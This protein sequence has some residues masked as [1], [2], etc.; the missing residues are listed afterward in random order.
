MNL[1]FLNAGRRCELL[2]SFRQALALRGGGQIHASDV[3]EHAPA[4]HHADYAHR[5]PH[6]SAA[7][8]VPAF[9]A[10]CRSAAIDLVIPTIDPDLDFLSRCRPEIERICPR[11][12][13]LLSP[14]PVIALCRDKRFTRARFAELGAA[15]PLAVDPDDDAVTFPIFM[16]P[17]TGSASEGIR[18]LRHRE[19]LAVHRCDCAEP[20][21]EQ[22]VTGPE[23]TV[24]VLC[25]FEGR[26]R[27]AV[28]RKRLQVRGGEVVKGVVERHHD[29][30]QLAMRLAE[31]FGCEGPVTLQF[32][33]PSAT[34]P[35][36]AM[37]INARMGGGLPLSIAAGADWPGW[38]LDLAAG[39]EPDFDRPLQDGLMMLRYD[40]SV[41]V[42][43]RPPAPAPLGPPIT[44]FDRVEALVFDLDDTLYPERD[45]VYGGH[46]A[47]AERVF[48]DH[49][50]DVE[51]ILRAQFESGVRSNRFGRA[52][53]ALGVVADEAYLR[54]LVDV[55]RGH[56]CTLRPFVAT[57]GLP[58]LRRAGYR[59]GLVTDG[60]AAVQRRKLAAVGLAP[61]FDAVVYTDELG[62]RSFWKPSQVPFARC[63][64][65]LGVE[66]ARA[67]YIADNPLKDFSG[68]RALGM[69]TVRVRHPDG[70][71]ARREPAT[72]A[73]AADVEIASLGDLFRLFPG[74]AENLR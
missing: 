29:L 19:D 18:V 72:S 48:L 16:K 30:E 11:V 43:A 53:A 7:D 74:T 70:E 17:S 9:T 36:V 27:V 62:D 71:H 68:A 60:V 64:A 40:A 65:V 42:P 13:L 33:R 67:V 66:P 20:M 32:R 28:V 3:V 35:F 26:A 15:V 8:F 23:Y 41:F 49:G 73:D 10:L 50:I 39:R 52:L 57:A 12:R 38:I 63:L 58:G 21:F 46:R 24:D 31:G 61:L 25:D 47:V 22:I 34:D 45:F 55:Y 56:A 2:Q 51:P 5:L 14:A 6:G 4:L 37:E 44:R 69:A 59:L 1:L 54:T